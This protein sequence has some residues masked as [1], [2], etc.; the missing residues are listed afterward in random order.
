[1]SLASSMK[2]PSAV[3]KLEPGSSKKKTKPAEAPES[4]A[5]EPAKD[6]P[7]E[8]AEASPT[9]PAEAP[10]PKTAEAGKPAKPEKAPS[11]KSDQTLPPPSKAAWNDMKYQCQSLAKKGKNT[12]PEGL[13]RGPKPGTNG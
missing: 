4:E 2:R 8:P 7:P 10:V 5:E 11:R 13:A 6:L 9:K 3:V 1:M 12:S